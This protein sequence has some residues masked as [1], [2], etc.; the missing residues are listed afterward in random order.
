MIIEHVV[1]STKFLKD[2]YDVLKPGGIIICICHNERHFLSKILKEFTQENNSSTMCGEK[3]YT[4]SHE[5]LM[6][7]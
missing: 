1:D 5:R 6:Y 3:I 4:L 2:I 7:T